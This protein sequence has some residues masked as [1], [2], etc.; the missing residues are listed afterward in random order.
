[1]KYNLYS[2]RRIQS[3]YKGNIMNQDQ[4]STGGH[5]AGMYDKQSGEW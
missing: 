5:Q 1:M 2:L 4:R 3:L